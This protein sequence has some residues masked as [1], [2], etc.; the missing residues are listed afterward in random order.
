MGKQNRKKESDQKD[1]E[2]VK[3]KEKC[4][5]HNRVL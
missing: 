1:K 5:T 2:G 4:I 3:Y